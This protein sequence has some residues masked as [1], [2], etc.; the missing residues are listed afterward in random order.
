[1]K[2]Y[3]MFAAGLLAGGMLMYAIPAVGSAVQTYVLTKADYPVVVNGSPVGGAELPILNYE[4]STYIPM[5][6]VGEILGAE[7][8]WN[9]AWK[10]AEIR[11]GEGA[12]VQNAAFRK[13]EV[14]GQNGAYTVTGEARVFEAVM[15]YAVSDGHRYLIEEFRT[16]QEGAPA[17]SAFTL[18]LDIPAEELPVNGTLTLELFEYSAKDG[19]IT[20]LLII[21]LETFR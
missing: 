4:G 19:E 1:M 7:V 6:A 13:L 10:R 17:W 11:Y 18:K 14:T 8:S 2:S 21:P 3:R 9:D 5:R 12:A 15:Q 20:N 16:L